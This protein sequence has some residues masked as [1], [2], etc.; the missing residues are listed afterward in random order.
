MQKTDTSKSP[1]LQPV[2]KR[3]Y[4]NG[5]TLDD[6]G[7]V[8][9]IN[10]QELGAGSAPPPP[11]GPDKNTAPPPPPPPGSFNIPDDTKGF[12]FNDIPEDPNDINEND[13][14]DGV[15]ISSA[16]AKTFANVVGDAIQ[17]YIPQLTYK[18]CEVD[19]DSVKLHV[20]R[21]ILTTNFIEFF[22]DVNSRAKEALKISDDKIK[23]WKKA[24]KDYLEYKNFK[25]ANPET[26]FWVA[27]GVLATDITVSTYMLRKSHI[28]MM[29]QAIRHCSPDLFI[30]REPANKKP[31]LTQKE[32]GPEHKA[33]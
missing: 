8:T 4:T 15:S 18:I 9:K 31:D 25:A 20:E 28:E 13:H 19:M 24:F 27:C 3:E 6:K 29:E 22:D 11:P 12:T 1:L 7:A 30:K 23:M 33:A 14:S 2:I 32:D 5:L 16:S 10:Q 17:M 21:G 26:A